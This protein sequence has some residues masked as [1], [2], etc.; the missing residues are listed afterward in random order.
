LSQPALDLPSGAAET[1]GASRD[2]LARRTAHGF[3]WLMAQTIGSKLVG[4]AGQIVLAWL[5]MPE[6]L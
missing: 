5:L 4:M 2:N 1:A 6:P 3:V